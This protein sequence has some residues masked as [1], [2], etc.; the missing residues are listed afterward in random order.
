[1]ATRKKASDEAAAAV[2]DVAV[3]TAANPSESSLDRLAKMF[4]SFMMVQRA[5]D[6]KL[7][8]ESAQQA[9][10]YA[11][12]AHQV[13]QLQLDVEAVRERKTSPVP[14]HGATT[15][16]PAATARGGKTP[17]KLKMAKL[18]DADNIDHYLTTFEKLAAACEWPKAD[19][20][21]HL[22]PLLTGKARSA[23]I[24]MDPENNTDFDRL[25]EAI[26]KKYDINA[27]TYR[28]QFRALD[29]SQD[30]T[31]Q[32]LYI[33]LKDL[34]CK[35]VKY[36]SCSK[37]ALMETMVLEQYLRILYPEVRTWV[38]E[39][40][41]ATAAEAAT[42]V[43][44]FVAAHKGSKRFRYAGVWDHPPWGKS[45]G[46]GRGCGSGSYNRSAQPPPQGSVKSQG[47]SC[48]NCGREGHKS[49][50]CPLRKPKHSHLC[51]VPNPSPPLK[52]QLSRDPV[53]TVELNGKPTKAL[54]DTG[55]TQ[56]LVQAD[57]V[58]LECIN[59]NDKLTICCVHGDQTE[60]STADAYVKVCGQ[61]YLLSVGLVPKL[62]YPVLLGQDLP[63]L[64]DL[65]G[66]TAL[67]CVVTRAM[68]K[69][70][71]IDMADFPFYGED[72]PVEPA[73]TREER[74]AKRRQT[75][76]EIIEHSDLQSVTDVDPP[77]LSDADVRFSGDIADIQRAD[78]TLAHCLRS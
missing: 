58:P 19:W 39:R 34:F 44:N 72:V 43:E 29:T 3:A 71:P 38:K 16:R 57:L 77:S 32:E 17:Y 53:I 20:A 1:M 46:V 70:K 14:S 73:C 26:L 4:E 37:E 27:E 5:R 76:E 42:M 24:A 23:F 67:A 21:I 6:D 56:T 74:C 9:Q 40:N 59:E 50:A 55:C 41:P 47:V 69:A 18:E 60:H 64:S 51:Y 13:T 12:L 31:P 36:D 30:E 52:N 15:E 75:V 61:T 66:R 28:S 22:I 63:V 10:Q 62:P 68:A 78:L 65:V 35:W 25:K 45:D 49:P 7:E 54:V 48:F 8:R 33:R 11:D 2:G